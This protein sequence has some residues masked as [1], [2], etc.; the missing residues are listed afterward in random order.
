MDIN[1][2]EGLQVAVGP[3]FLQELESLTDIGLVAH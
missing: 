2:E 1:G 3:D